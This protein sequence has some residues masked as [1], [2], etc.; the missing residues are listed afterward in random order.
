MK[1]S[2]RLS[3]TGNKLPISVK[4]LSIGCFLFTLILSPAFLAAQVQ[5]GS[6]IGYVAPLAP[7]AEAA[8]IDAFKQGLQELG[9]AEGKNIT[10]E[11]RYA[12]GKS[13]HMPALFN[14]LIQLKSDV[15]VAEGL[16]TTRAAKE[17]TSTIPIVMITANDPVA[18]GIIDSL[19]RPGGNITGLTRLTR[20]LS[21]KRIELL[22][23]A[24]PRLSR[25]GVVWNAD[26]AA[27]A[28]GFKA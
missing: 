7:A 18:S 5:K 12:H 21:G 23:E 17:A 20:D 2:D 24:V 19:A 9:Y 28:N 14:E 13:D 6:R 27:A 10:I 4:T 26:N 22:H 15:L 25:I 16:T 3:A 11:F 8:R 1:F